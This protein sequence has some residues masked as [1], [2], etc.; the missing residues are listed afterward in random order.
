M[1]SPT[2]SAG[3]PARPA[4]EEFRSRAQPL[5]S[6]APTAPARV[7]RGVPAPSRPVLGVDI[8]SLITEDD[9][10][11]DNMLSEKQQR[12]LT[13]PLY[14]SWAGPGA[15]R[16][17][18]AAANVGVF[19]EPRNP[20][21]VPDVFLS[22]D[23][24]ANPNWWHREHR[25]YF[26]WVFGK[27]PD[28]VVEI[29]SNRKGSEIDGKRLSYARMGVRYYVVY[30]PLH[31]VMRDD[32][33]VYRLSDGSYD[34]QVAARFP[35]LGLGMM[36]WEGEFEDSR[37]TWLRWTDAGGGM[38]LTGQEAA[39]RERGRTAQ[40]RQRTDRERQLKEQAQ[41]RA[42]HERQLKEQAQQRAE[43]ER[44]LKDQER[45]R[46]EREQR[47]AERLAA[48]LRRAGIDPEQEQD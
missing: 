10:P 37:G 35:E 12:L 5:S 38:I 8:E 14:S 39:E 32:L 21:I 34:R 42:E 6:V 36:L 25:S 18:L 2:F 9:E 4:P 20:A 13:R 23:V 1:D 33:R 17:F 44:R 31:V 27:P 24:R 48:L 22:L 11:V 40:Q 16:T 41:Q 28:L 29:V 46:A 43:H 45:E 47:R 3:E 26:V 19:P 30:D 7:T 15:G